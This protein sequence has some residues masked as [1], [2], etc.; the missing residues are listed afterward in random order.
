MNTRWSVNWDFLLVVFMGAKHNFFFCINDHFLYSHSL[1]LFLILYFGLFSVLNSIVFHYLFIRFVSRSFF[2]LRCLFGVFSRHNHIR[3]VVSRCFSLRF[4]YLAM[5][6]FFVFSCR[7]IIFIFVG[8]SSCSI[9]QLKKQNISWITPQCT[10]KNRTQKK[11][12]HFILFFV[13]SLCD[14][15]AF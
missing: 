1:L 14:F 5:C 11:R 2:L 3:F 7:H 13:I 6:F 9:V 15:F 8:T 10:N 4:Q 12:F